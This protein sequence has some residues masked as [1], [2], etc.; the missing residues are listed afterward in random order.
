VGY[1]LGALALGLLVL[2][3]VRAIL[4]RE[5]AGRDSQVDLVA[6]AASPEE[7]RVSRV[8]H[9][10]AETMLDKARAAA[11]RGDYRQAVGWAYLAGLAALHRGGFVDLGISTT[12]LGIVDETRR[13]GGPHGPAARLVRIFEDLFFGARAATEDHWRE[14]RRIAEEELGT[15]PAHRL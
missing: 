7:V 5:R 10:P 8:A 2:L 12:N 9:V 4:R 14:C 3:V 15:L 6:G 11:A 1:L 13:R